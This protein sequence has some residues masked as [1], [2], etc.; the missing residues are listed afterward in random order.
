MRNSL[1]KQKMREVFDKVRKEEIAS[2]SARSKRSIT[3]GRTPR[4]GTTII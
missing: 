4:T 2:E 1:E 3:F